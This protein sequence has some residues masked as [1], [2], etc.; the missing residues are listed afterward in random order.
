[1][2]PLSRINDPRRINDTPRQHLCRLCCI[3]RIRANRNKT[4]KQKKQKSRN[5]SW[6]IQATNDRLTKG[7]QRCHGTPDQL[8]KLT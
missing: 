5:Q 4:R 7:K 8:L 1:L 3:L 2:L 6:P